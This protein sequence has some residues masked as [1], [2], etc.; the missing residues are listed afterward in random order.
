M[1]ISGQWLKLWRR[2]S[3]SNLNITQT[4]HFTSVT[5]LGLQ[6]SQLSVNPLRYELF[7]HLPVLFVLGSNFCSCLLVETSEYV[8]IKYV[9]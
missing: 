3:Q 5:L 7:K 4:A 6:P 8:N 9:H 1:Y 2:G